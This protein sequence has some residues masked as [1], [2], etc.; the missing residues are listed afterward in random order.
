MRLCSTEGGHQLQSVSPL[1][2]WHMEDGDRIKLSES[3]RQVAVTKLR[4]SKL[5]LPSPL[6]KGKSKKC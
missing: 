4:I 3:F 5:L 1:L 2:L 6:V